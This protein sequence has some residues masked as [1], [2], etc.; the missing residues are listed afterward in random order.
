MKRV[1]TLACL[2]A[3]AAVQAVVAQADFKALLAKVDA[4][5]SF[6][7]DFSAEYT[8]M[9]ENPGVGTS[10]T[11]L[12][13]FR[14]DKASKYLILILKPE[15]DKGKGYLKIDGSLWLYDPVGRSFTFTSSQERFQNS[16]ARNSDFTRSTLALDYDIAGSKREKLGK[17][18]C[19]V[20]DL[21]ANNNEVSFPKMRVWISDDNLVRKSEDYS[22]SGQLMRTTAIPTYQKVG[23]RFVPVDIYLVDAL[24]GKTINGKFQSEKTKISVAKPSLAPVPDSVYSKAY[25]EKVGK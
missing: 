21:R 9:Q 24:R 7:G 6:D 15:S 23:D 14:R 1:R 4:L 3:F 22:L 25:L 8:V 18:D 11:T 12:A 20:L 16:N 19:W 5:V 17:F 10:V 2:C 13:M